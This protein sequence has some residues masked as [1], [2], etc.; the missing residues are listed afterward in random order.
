[1]N[2]LIRAF[3]P[4]C[5]LPDSLCSGLMGAPGWSTIAPKAQ[6]SVLVTPVALASGVLRELEQFISGTNCDWMRI[7]VGRETTLACYRDRNSL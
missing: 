1:M 6:C 4:S 7:R 2:G 3:T 5:H